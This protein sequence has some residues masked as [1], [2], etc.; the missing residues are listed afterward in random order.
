MLSIDATRILLGI[1]LLFLGRRLFWL[2]VG[3]VGF[4]AGLRL[5]EQMLPGRP[6]EV[7]IVFSLVVGLAAAVLAIALRKIALALAGFL[8]GGYLLLQLLAATTGTQALAVAGGPEAV[9]AGGQ[10]APWVVFIVG[11]LIGAVLMNVVFDWT[12]I[13]LSALGGSALI[14]QCIHG[15]GAQIITIIFTTLTILGVLSQ[16]GLIRRRNG[17]A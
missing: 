6:D 4:V 14:C 11:G 9:Q 12:L 2:F 7:V 10:I 1:L 16:A 5:A 17:P 3:V 15:V 13:F 8:A